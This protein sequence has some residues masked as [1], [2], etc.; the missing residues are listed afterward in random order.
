MLPDAR[1]AEAPV[2]RSS[3][4][5]E[6]AGA[7]RCETVEVLWDGKRV[8]AL[9]FMMS[10]RLGMKLLRM[11][12][13]TRT[14]D[15][16]IAPPASKPYQR[17]ANI[18]RIVRGL[19]DALPRH[20]HFEIALDPD[21]D[22]AVP[23]AFDYAGFTVSHAFTFRSA[24]E[25]TLPGIWAGMDK[26]TR[27]LIRSAGNRCTVVETTDFDRFEHLSR[28]EQRPERTTHDYGLLRRLHAQAD[29]RQQA[30]VLFAT[31][32]GR[33]AASVILLWDHAVMYYWTSARDRQ[34][35]GGSS[36]LLLW[37]ALGMAKARGLILDMDGY[38]A[39][40]SA[41]FL[42]SFG[43]PP[44]VRPVVARSSRRYRAARLMREALLSSR[45]EAG[46]S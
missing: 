24:P 27:N 28:H 15:P 1:E 38:C 20:D 43:A 40:A 31:Q 2:F 34:C 44:I 4:W 7:G 17:V 9:T 45:H 37:H 13:Y 16:F 30:A 39:A 19:A 35:G 18:R 8:G 46:S 5:L 23:F 11:P 25:D 14:L 29:A 41:H 3:W 12:P 21:C 42:A 22:P 6:A 10:H 26:K 36:A 32:D 33:D